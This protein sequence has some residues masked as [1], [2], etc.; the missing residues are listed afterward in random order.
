M[1]YLKPLILILLLAT[2]IVLFLLT[3]LKEFLDPERLLSLIQSAREKWWTPTLIIAI[4]GFGGLV[5]IPAVP[6]TLGIGAVYGLGYGMLYSTLAANLGAVVDFW[7]ARYLGREFVARI[8]KGKWRAFDDKVAAH[9]LRY[10]FYLRLVPLFPYLGINFAAGLSKIRFRDYWTASFFGM[11]PC[12]FVYTYFA[13]SLLAGV[14]EAKR[15]ALIHLIL[16]S[17]LL[18]LLSLLP[19][20]VKKFRRV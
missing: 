7:A 6:L 17:L 3:P 11:I 9:G 4:Y 16:S 10:I 12:T 15:D 1:R 20:I 8:L 13:S 14:V 2:G 18:V 5:A 19:L